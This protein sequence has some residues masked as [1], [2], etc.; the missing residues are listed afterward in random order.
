MTGGN[1]AHELA[2]ATPDSRNRYV[3]LLRVVSIVAVVIGHWLLA[4]V[5]WDGGFTGNNLLVIAPSLHIATWVFQVM[6]L[7]FI[8]GGFVNGPSW[9]SAVSRGT[10][11]GGWL[12]TRSARLLRP[13]LVFVAFWTILPS[14]GVAFGLAPDFAR[15][16]GSEVA[17][18]LWFLA[19]Y[20]AMMI[21][22]PPLMAV[23]DR[24]GAGTFFIL[25]AA[26]AA[27]DI[28][29]YGLD[30]GMLG[31][32][33]FLFIWLAML[34]LGICWRDG[35]LTDRRWL[36]WAMAGGGL[37][38]LAVLT[39]AFDYPVSMIHLFDSPRSNA[40]PPTFALLALGVWQCGAV[41]IFEGPA[42]RWLQRPRVWLAVV[43]SNSMIMTL[44]LW[45]MS[46]VVLAALVL[47][48]TGIAPQ[49][50]QLS[51][52]WW[53]LRPGWV[54]ACA[55]C[56]APFVL[57]FR[58]AERPVAGAPVQIASSIAVAGT[59]LGVTGMGI[60]AVSAFPVPGEPS[61]V[62]AM[63][64]LAIAAAALMLRIDP[65][66]PLRG[67]TNRRRLSAEGAEGPA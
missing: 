59:V 57:G 47:L 9:R 26:T 21:L 36:P 42:N 8:V 52:Q 61:G 16:G 7:F 5:G 27:I 4:V 37:A 45:N 64:L 67:A 30:L 40:M 6:P 50:E 51:P 49:P 46:A 10:G 33:N 31:A 23:H 1:A 56:L 43:V 34:E 53:A 28:A 62:Q 63:G 39:L 55:V 60:I 22:V 32:P 3:D 24:W 25:A 38:V 41:L 66:A 14:L 15:L 17:L 13:A 2:K 11:Y 65:F 20:L 44:Y 48:P 19:V 58:W 18:P 12:R 35:T 29:R 54:L